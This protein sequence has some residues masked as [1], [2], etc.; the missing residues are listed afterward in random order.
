MEGPTNYAVNFNEIKE[1]HQRIKDF[2]HLTPVLSNSTIN[3]LSGKQLYFKCENFQKSCSFKFRGASNAILKLSEEELKSGVVT[4]SS[5]NHGQGLAKAAK[6]KNTK[7]YIVVPSNAPQI[8]INAIRDYGA[9]VVLCE[10]TL[11]AR[12][13]NCQNLI[14]KHGCTLVHPFDNESII[15]GQGTVA[16]ELLEQVPDLDCI[17]CPVGGGGLL[18]GICIAAKAIK[19]NIKVIAAEPEGADDAFRSKQAGSVQK[20]SENKPNTIADGLLTTVGSRNWPIIRDLCDEIITVSDQEI[21]EAMRLIWERMKIIVEP[22]SATALA[23]TLKQQFKDKTDLKKVGI[24]I[25]GGNVDL[26]KWKW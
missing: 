18:S 25:S 17:V 19:P 1:S 5:G 20:H 9:E 2:I 8:K 21:K 10:P 15:Q 11:V 4:H 13:T 3:E 7:A 24:V 23:I 22:S 26:D 12:E 6:M 14:D 16:L